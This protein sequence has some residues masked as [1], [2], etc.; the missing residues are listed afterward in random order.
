MPVIQLDQ[1]KNLF[2]DEAAYR[3]FLGILKHAIEGG[4]T[5]MVFAGTDENPFA[6]SII[7]LAETKK[8]LCE[9]ILDR[10]GESPALMAELRDR[11]EN[12][13]IVD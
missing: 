9:R 11:L 8:V 10:L 3:Q 12:D 7:S 6:F 2:R 13:P 1:L 5:P 4:T